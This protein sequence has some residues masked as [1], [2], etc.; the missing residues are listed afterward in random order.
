MFNHSSRASH[1][2]RPTDDTDRRPEVPADVGP[3]INMQRGEARYSFLAGIAAHEGDDVL[4]SGF[5]DSPVLFHLY[6]KQR[7]VISKHLSIIFY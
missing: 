4:S 5:K 3:M 7:K 2:S 1:G 6:W